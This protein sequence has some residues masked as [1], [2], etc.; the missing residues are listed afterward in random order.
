MND[1]ENIGLRIPEN[2][3]S[4]FSKDLIREIEVRKLEEELTHLGGKKTGFQ[5]PLNYFEKNSENLNKLA[6]RNTSAPAKS[7]LRILKYWIPIG[8]AAAIT[9]LLMFGPLKKDLEEPVS[10]SSALFSELLAR[11]DIDETVLDELAL[12]DLAEVVLEDESTLWLDDTSLEYLLED[13]E[14]L[15]ELNSEL[16]EF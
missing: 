13:E 12:D 8:A 7:N 6:S 14:L 2:Y 1:K 10:D 3:F 9:A 5:V 4:D 16:N 11:L 15:N